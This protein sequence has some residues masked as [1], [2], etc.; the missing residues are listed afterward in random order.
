MKNTMIEINLKPEL[1]T[2]EELNVIK[3]NNPNRSVHKRAIEALYQQDMSLYKAWCVNLE[4]CKM[5]LLF[6]LIVV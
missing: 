4:S 1:L 3:E 2:K 5:D 6:I